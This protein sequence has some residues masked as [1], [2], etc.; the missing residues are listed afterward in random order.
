MEN[1]RGLI[2]SFQ[3]CHCVGSS[4]TTLTSIG[5]VS[6]NLSLK[7]VDKKLQI[8]DASRISTSPKKNI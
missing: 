6:S 8:T 4:E 7:I 1:E 5:H 2:I 3:N